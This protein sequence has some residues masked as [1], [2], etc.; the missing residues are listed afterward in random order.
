[1]NGRSIRIFLV[2]GT[3]TG[4]RTAELGLSTIKALAI[5]RASLVSVSA[6]EEIQK[7]GVYVLIGADS[8]SPGQKRIYVGEGDVLLTRLASHNKSEDKDFWDECVVFV[9]KDQN[10]TKSHARYVEAR[11]IKLAADAKRVALSNSTAPETKGWLPEADQV[12]MEQFIDQARLLLG[13]LGY[14]IFESQ[15]STPS[16]TTPEEPPN[17][18]RRASPEFRFSGDGFDARCFVDEDAGEFVVLGDSLAR[19]TELPSL[20]PTYRNLRQRLLDIGV[21][22]DSGGSSYRFTQDY[23]FRAPSAAAQV[24]CGYAVNGRNAFKDGA[25]MTLASWQDKQLPAD[26]G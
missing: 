25:G 26:L 18:T 7:T 1:M 8:D 17:P 14:N 11:L 22:V 21:L 23:S 2:D 19:K 5:P 10:L 6:R 4:V 9:S 24:V 3:P 12:E 16:L 20:Q 13:T 15:Q